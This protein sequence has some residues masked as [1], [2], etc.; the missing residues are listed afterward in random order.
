MADR[1]AVE[2]LTFDVYSALFDFRTTLV[3]PLEAALGAAG[4][5]RAKPLLELWRMRQL[6]LAMQH[7]ML[8][9]G[10]LSFRRA[11]ALSLDYALAMFEFDLS[12]ADRGA[13][14]HAWD[15]LEPWPEAPEALKAL[16][17]EGYRLGLLSNGDQA[18]LEALAVRLPGIDTVLSAERAGAYKPHPNVYWHALNTLDVER[19]ALVHVAG[20][21]TDVMGA[22]SA[23]LRCAWSNRFGDRML[24]PR[25]E[26]TLTVAHLAQLPAALQT[27]RRQQVT[28]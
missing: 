19:D 27:I 10:H 8:Q 7:A 18:M 6:G 26:A 21:S 24:D 13:L 1:P 12:Q 2:W 23:G 14:V 5:D 3:P 15:A 16:K 20:S 22:R 4:C 28:R 17:A 9:R 25:F 11:T